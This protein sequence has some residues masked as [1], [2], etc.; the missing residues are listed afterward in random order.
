MSATDKK[1]IKRETIM[2]LIESIDDS[3]LNLVY[4]KLKE[5]KASEVDLSK[6][7]KPIPKTIDIEQLKKEQNWKPLDK[8]RFYKVIDE[9]DIQ[10]SI[11]ELIAQLD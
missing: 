5:I 9:M 2:E 4:S 1:N 3:K 6:Y 7:L 10:E 11:E 8:E